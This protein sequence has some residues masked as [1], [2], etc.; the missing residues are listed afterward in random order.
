MLSGNISQPY[1]NYPSHLLHESAKKQPFQSSEK[2]NTSHVNSNNESLFTDPKL[3]MMMR[4]E[5]PYKNYM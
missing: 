1:P 2:K 5:V 3:L 4:G